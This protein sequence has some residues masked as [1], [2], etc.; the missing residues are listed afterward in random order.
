MRHTHSEHT[1]THEYI[2]IIMQRRMVKYTVWSFAW[3]ARLD[4]LHIQPN[5][6]LGECKWSML[7]L[8]V[9]LRGWVLGPILCCLS[10]TSNSLLQYQ[11]PIH[12]ED[13]FIWAAIT[14]GTVLSKKTD[15]ISRIWLTMTSSGRVNFNYLLLAMT[16][17]FLDSQVVFVPKFSQSS[18]D[19]PKKTV[20]RHKCS[21]EDQ[22]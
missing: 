16:V 5:V 9:I 12:S 4:D 1:C 20:M 15:S 17:V 22:L 14:K 7:Q 21:C 11:F 3:F 19:C 18:C 6:G 2:S 13:S 8:F 10:E